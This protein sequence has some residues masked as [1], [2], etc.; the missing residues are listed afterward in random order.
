[1]AMS[2]PLGPTT[3]AA[4]A[5]DLPLEP[6]QCGIR[7]FRVSFPK[8]RPVQGQWLLVAARKGA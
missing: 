8:E 3:G 7:R 4:R 5:Q 2:G 1:M 6:S